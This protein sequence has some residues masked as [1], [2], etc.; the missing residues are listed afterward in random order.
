MVNDYHTAIEKALIAF[1]SKQKIVKKCLRGNEKP[2]SIVDSY[3]KKVVNYKPD[4]YFILNNR[5]KILFQ[6]LESELYSQDTIIA[7]VV[8]ACFVENCHGII[9]IHSSD[10]AEDQD[11]VL[12]ALATM[13]RGMNGKGIASEELPIKN[14]AYTISRKLAKNQSKTTAKIKR[15]CNTDKWF[16]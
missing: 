14:Y 9:F 8:R 4:V 10:K 11:R 7:D 6:V 3:S 5:L 12:E 2:I 1:G 13:I 15:F 16:Q